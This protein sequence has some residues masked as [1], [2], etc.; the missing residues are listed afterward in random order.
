VIRSEQEINLILI[1]TFSSDNDVLVEIDR[2]VERLI[3]VHIVRN[4]QLYFSFP[5]SP[6]SLR[7][8]TI[9]SPLFINKVRPEV[10]QGSVL[11]ARKM[12]L[13]P[14]VIHAGQTAILN[15]TA[16]LGYDFMIRNATFSDFISQ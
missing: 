2:N 1:N 4:Q 10:I 6:G 5:A 13:S 9:Q 16:N 15:G 14:G 11:P 8:L 12:L 3:H 7:H